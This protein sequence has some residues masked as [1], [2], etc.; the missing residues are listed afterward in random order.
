MILRSK[1][2]IKRRW[3]RACAF[4]RAI[5][6]GATGWKSLK[7]VYQGKHPHDRLNPGSLAHS[8]PGLTWVTA[9]PSIQSPMS[10]GLF[11]PCSSFL[12]D[13]THRKQWTGVPLNL[14]IPSAKEKKTHTGSCLKSLSEPQRFMVLFSWT[15]GMLASKHTLVCT[16]ILIPCDPAHSSQCQVSPI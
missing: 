10:N 1:N 9:Q 8:S 3:I 7:W 2:K 16:H 5:C 4:S 11:S 6:C 15:P 13:K 12:L 14:F